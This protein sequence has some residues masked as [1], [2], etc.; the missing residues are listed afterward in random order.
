MKTCTKCSETK[1]LTEFYAVGGQCKECVRARV[2][3]HR[4]D[5]PEIH[6]ERDRVR[7]ANRWDYL[8]KQCKKYREASPEK[9]KA[10]T[11]VSNA[12]RD[13]KLT[14]EVCPCGESKVEAHH[15]DYSKPLD[16]QWLCIK[17]HTGLH[18]S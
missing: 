13:G 2:R 9:Y 14:K 8:S 15:A 11:A 7:N 5:N 10:R 12:L 4:A 17:C 1:E 18:T 3:K 6:K 16:V